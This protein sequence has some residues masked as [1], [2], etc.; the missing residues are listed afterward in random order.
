MD[1]TAQAT[2]LQTLTQFL[3]LIVI[4]IVMFYMMNSSSRKEKKKKEELMSSLKKND[5]IQTIGG[6]I[7]TVEEILPT[8]VKITIDPQTRTTMTF[9]KASISNII[10]TT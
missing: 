4:V 7:G 6:I 1:G 9:A 2:G 5:R 3:P 10:S 8:E